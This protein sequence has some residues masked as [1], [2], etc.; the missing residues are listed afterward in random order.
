MLA[1]PSD[2]DLHEGGKRF[3]AGSW[4]HHVLRRWVQSGAKLNHKKPLKLQRLE[5]LPGEL[6]FRTSDDQIQL[7]AIAHWEDG[8]V[9]D[10]TDI[11][12]FSSNDDSIAAV[13]ENGQVKS[14]DKGDTH[15]VVFYDNAVVPVPVLRPIGPELQTTQATKPIDQLIEQKLNKL[16]VQPSGICNDSEFVR[17]ASLDITGILPTGDRVREFLTDNSPN[18]RQQLVNELLQSDGYSAWWATRLS[19]WTG[20]SEEQ[21]NNAL[22]VRGAGTRMWHE[23]LRVRSG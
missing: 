12:R 2:A 13:D 7:Q 16:G 10:V 19:D 8:T 3:D 9:E 15:L 14:G 4:Q 20:N 1:K 6:R 18:K 23:W 21:L 5:I 11:C 17:R 22:P